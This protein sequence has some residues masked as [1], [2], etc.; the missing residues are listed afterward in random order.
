[1]MML[2]VFSMSQQPHALFGGSGA[3]NPPSVNTAA[4]HST[5]R[6]SSSSSPP[7]V[8]NPYANKARNAHQHGETS[9][10]SLSLPV[11]QATTVRQATTTTTSVSCTL[12]PNSASST[13]KNSTR[14]SSKSPPPPPP[15]AT[16]IDFSQFQSPTTISNTTSRSRV[17]TSNA[18]RNNSTTE[19][20]ANHPSTKQNKIPAKGTPGSRPLQTKKTTNA[21]PKSPDALSPCNSQSS[22]VKSTSLPFSFLLQFAAGSS[23]Q[24]AESPNPSSRKLPSTEHTSPKQSQKSASSSTPHSKSPN[25]EPSNLWLGAD[26]CMMEMLNDDDDEE[27]GDE[28]QA[29]SCS[30]TTRK[31]TTVATRS[32]RQGTYSKGAKY[33]CF[34]V[35]VSSIGLCRHGYGQ[36]L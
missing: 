26:A 7:L 18:Q 34:V 8:S 4:S 35:S 30:P 6:L 32:T 10:S 12:P 22:G 25:K 23:S 1:M 17:S 15:A 11:N 19:A 14:E 29:K 9:S 24:T 13:N 27:N 36:S 2:V 5:R 28:N 16:A 33:I 21:L 20:M 31:E 3:T